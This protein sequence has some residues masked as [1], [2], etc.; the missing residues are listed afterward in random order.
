MPSLDIAFTQ[1]SGG[2]SRPQ[3]DALWTGREVV[4]KRDCPVSE[5]GLDTPALLA[6]ADG[7][8]ASQHPARA[9][10]FVMEAT[11][12]LDPSQRLMGRQVRH[13]HERLAQRY[14]GTRS[15][16]TATTLVAARICEGHCELVNVGDS[17]AYLIRRDGRWQQLSHDHTVLNELIASGEIRPEEGVEYAQMYQDL[18]HCLTADTEEYGFALHFIETGFAK[19]DA[20]L[21]CSDGL[22]DAIGDA[23]IRERY[24][25]ERSAA[26]KVEQWRKAV[27]A[28]GVPDN[29]SIL[30]ARRV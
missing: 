7:V 30:L 9:S 21:L 18:A 13:I 24:Q 20:L 16:G 6:V 17:R 19:G 8:A 22:H 1:H 5:Q 15:H 29:L 26:E 11:G 3:Q 28:A 14:A 23:A 10:R 2:A 4:Q 12:N 27:I 25:P